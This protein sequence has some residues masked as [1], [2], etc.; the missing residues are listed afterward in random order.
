MNAGAG[1]EALGRGR[2]RVRVKICGITTPADA[3]AAE[4]AG[5]DAVGMI[6]APSKRRVDLPA[7]SEIVAALGPFVTTVG[8]FRDTPL[9]EVVDILERLR[10]DV[11][12]LH[13]SE[14]AGYAAA[15]RRHA[16]VMRAYS[17]AEAPGPEALLDYP[18]DAILLDAA[19]PGSGERF[20]WRAAAAWR[21]HP[22]LVL[23][24]GLD[25]ENVAEAVAALQPYAVDVASGV[26]RSPGVKDHELMN[27]FVE[28][29][30]GA[31]RLA[32]TAEAAG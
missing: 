15:V 29:A 18:A 13:G 31:G 24:G 16:R 5:A 6:F 17:H 32:A 30:R 9:D 22:R 26:E 20:D 1:G 25:P 21:G 23:A 10:L 3:R 14:G 4:R 8:V 11:A 7:A 19:R 27:R 2:A 28:R 12:Q